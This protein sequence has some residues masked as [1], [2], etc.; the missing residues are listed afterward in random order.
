MGE[1]DDGNVIYIDEYNRERWLLKLRVA[2]A[3]GQVAVFNA[4]QREEHTNLDNLIIFPER[5]Q[6]DG[7][8]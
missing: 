1:I 4:K 6:P 2:R 7:A 8:A 3:T 5:P